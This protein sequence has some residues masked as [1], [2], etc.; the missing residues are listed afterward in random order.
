LTSEQIARVLA[1]HD[2][3]VTLKQ[4]AASLGVSTCTVV[5][6]INSRGIHYKQAPP[7]EREASLNAHHAH[8][9]ALREANLL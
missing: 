7:K 2:S 5:H 1:W 6:V 8:C 9:R 4:L 3:R